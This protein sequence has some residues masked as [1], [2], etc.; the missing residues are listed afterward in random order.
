MDWTR[1][2]RERLQQAGS[3]APP[4]AVVEEVAEHLEQR[5]DDAVAAGADPAAARRDVLTDLDDLQALAHV[6]RNS[7]RP[8]AQRAPMP[9]FSEGPHMW[10]DLSGDIRYAIRLLRRN[11]GFAAAALLTIA[12]GVG[13]G[14]RHLQ[15]RRRRAAQAVALSATPSGS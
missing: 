8:D 1:V 14:D 12:L 11:G 13:H 6:L 7:P 4:D 5:Y 9:P 3:A 2:V 15:R 10:S